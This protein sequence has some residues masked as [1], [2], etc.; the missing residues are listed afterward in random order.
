MRSP[1]RP[2]RISGNAT[3][4][5]LPPGAQPRNLYLHAGGELKFDAPSAQESQY[6][7]YAA[8]QPNRFP[9]CRSLQSEWVLSA[10]AHLQLLCRSK[11]QKKAVPPGTR[12]RWSSVP[13]ASR[14]SLP[15]P[16]EIESMSAQTAW[17]TNLAPRWRD[18]RCEHL[19][20]D[21]RDS[22][23]GIFAEEQHG[24]STFGPKAAVLETMLAICGRPIRLSSTAL[25][26]RST[27]ALLRICSPIAVRTPAASAA[28]A[29]S[30]DSVLSM[31][32]RS[33]TYITP[34]QVQLLSKES[35]SH[36]S[37]F[38]AR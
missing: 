7:E 25:R 14:R 35:S 12:G 36:T 20:T 33:E 13:A 24:G 4:R 1:S 19:D 23:C 16:Q 2:E 3:P 17:Q 21:E 15:S 18:R 31:L 38:D 29:T 32:S 8:I 5:G 37:K 9:P 28:A 22:I 30:S 6:D 34:L 11:C 10:G 26:A 27:A